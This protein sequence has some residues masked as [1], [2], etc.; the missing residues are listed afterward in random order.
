MQNLIG[1]TIVGIR[2]L[3]REELDDMDWYGDVPV[4]ILDNGTEI[5]ASQDSEGNG[6]GRFF[7]TD[8]E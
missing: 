6:P 2:R 8:P 7:V 3:S 4:L 1:R 5:L